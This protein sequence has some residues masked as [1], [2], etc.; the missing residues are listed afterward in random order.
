M[1]FMPRAARVSRRPRLAPASV[2][3]RQR[4]QA[5]ATLAEARAIKLMAAGSRQVQ[6]TKL[7]L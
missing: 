6:D 3:K 5:A 1:I 4:E 2:A 7:G